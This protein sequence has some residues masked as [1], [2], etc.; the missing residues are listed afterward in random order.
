MKKY[1]VLTLAIALTAMFQTPVF[2]KAVVTPSGLKYNDVVVGAGGAASAGKMVMVMYTGWL[3]NN[4]AKGKMFDSATDPKKPF[5]FTLGVGQVIPGWDEGVQGM[6]IGGKRTL[7]I[8]AKLAY[9]ARGAGD[10]IPPNAD[11]IFDVT[12]VGVK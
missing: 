3:N 10:A 4:G 12:L 2:A 1:H 7:M 6:K 11:L 5:V 9:G 8:P